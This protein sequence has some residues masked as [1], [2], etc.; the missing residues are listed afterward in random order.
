MGRNEEMA[1]AIKAMGKDLTDRS[2]TLMTKSMGA[3]GIDSAMIGGLDDE[4][5]LLIRDS[6]RLLDDMVRFSNLV[7]ELLEVHSRSMDELLNEMGKREKENTRI[8][9]GLELLDKGFN[10]LSDYLT[11]A[12]E[13]ASN[14]ISKHEDLVRDVAKTIEEDMIESKDE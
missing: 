2:M 11:D 6:M 4:Q 1:M 5:A 3:A 14:T 8:M 9:G 13:L 7:F 10:R 12:V